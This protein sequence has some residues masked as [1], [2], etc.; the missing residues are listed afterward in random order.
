MV[1]FRQQFLNQ[2]LPQQTPIPNQTQIPNQSFPS[3]TDQLLQALT[4]RTQ[5]N[6]Q[7]FQAGQEAQEQLQGDTLGDALIG[8]TQGRTGLADALGRDLTAGEK[9]ALGLD[10]KPVTGTSGAGDLAQAF[11]NSF[12]KGT[13]GR[14]AREEKQ[15]AT[16]KAEKIEE[17]KLSLQE[18][19][20]DL[21]ATKLRNEIKGGGL[22]KKSLLAATGSMRKEFTKLSGDFFKQRDAFGRVKASASDPSPAGDFAMIFNFLK[23]LD[24]GSTVREGEF[25]AAGAAGS[26]PTRIQGAFNRIESGQLLTTKQRGDFVNRAKKLFGSADAQHEKR[27]GTFANLAD[28]A[29]VPKEQV[30]LDLGLAEQ[31]A[32]EEQVEKP[33]TDST[34]DEIRDRLGISLPGGSS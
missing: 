3:G 8:Q 31:E 2:L 30:I 23:V 16:K 17:R 19:E 28:Q 29:G 11:I 1:D 15:I 22:D 12:S 34:D 9:F 21:K 24:P 14:L 10:G 33:P 13:K 26:L 18:N 20:F 7:R 6:Q 5:Q 25:K 4:Q 27:I 32:A